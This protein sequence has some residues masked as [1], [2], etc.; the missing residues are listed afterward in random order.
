MREH[1]GFVEPGQEI[2]SASFANNGI[3]RSFDM[4]E[5]PRSPRSAD[6]SKCPLNMPVRI[7]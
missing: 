4:M 7:C 5:S 2:N 1:G 3:D 6:S